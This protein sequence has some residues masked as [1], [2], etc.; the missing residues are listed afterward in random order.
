MIKMYNS[1]KKKKYNSLLPCLLPTKGLG[2]TES[3]EVD[4]AFAGQ[5][6]ESSCEIKGP[7]LQ[8]HLTKYLV[9]LVS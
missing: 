3:T 1:K 5:G 9:K 6:P 4:Q 2:L 7:V 8:S